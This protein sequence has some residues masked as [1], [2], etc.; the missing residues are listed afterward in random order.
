MP[1]YT[2]KHIR[3][4]YYIPVSTYRTITEYCITA[5]TVN[6]SLHSQTC[7][8]A[9]IVNVVVYLNVKDSA[10]TII[11]VSPMLVYQRLVFSREGL[12]HDVRIFFHHG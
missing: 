1:L 11:V 12:H 10:V 4:G 7:L 8:N 6:Y 5:Y 2:S 9:G 3:I